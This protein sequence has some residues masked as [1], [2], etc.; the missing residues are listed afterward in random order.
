M[1]SIDIYTMYNNE[2]I[3]LIAHFSKIYAMSFKIYYCWSRLNATDFITLT[4]VVAISELRALSTMCCPLSD[5]SNCF[6]FTV[7]ISLFLQEIEEIIWLCDCI[8]N[9]NYW[10][11]IYIGRVLTR[12]LWCW[13][14]AT[15][16][17][18]RCYIDLRRGWPC[19]LGDLFGSRREL[20]LH[21]WSADPEISAFSC[22]DVLFHKVNLLHPRPVYHNMY[23]HIY[24]YLLSC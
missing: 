4:Q 18:L 3:H 5:T 20:I 8:D 14:V 19:S 21:V 12:Y 7:E 15:G 10:H 22:I 9:F 24:T 16:A 17:Y 1:W 11:F 6:S 2:L 13:P 23:S